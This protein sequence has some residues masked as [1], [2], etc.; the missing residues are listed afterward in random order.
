MDYLQY[1]WKND[2]QIVTRKQLFYDG[3]SQS[4]STGAIKSLKKWGL[5]DKDGR[6]KVPQNQTPEEFREQCRIDLRRRCLLQV[7]PIKDYEEIK[8]KYNNY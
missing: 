8:C 5:M 3:F 1:S 4:K 2:G 7:N 6:I